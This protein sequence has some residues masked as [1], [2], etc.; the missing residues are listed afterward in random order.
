MKREYFLVILVLIL[1]MFLVSCSGG[2]TIVTPDTT[3]PVITLL[4]ENP[5]NLYVGDTYVE[6]GATAI[7][8]VD[9]DITSSVIIGGDVVNT[10]VVGTYV[11]TYN[12]S[13]SAGNTAI[14]VAIVINVGIPDG[15][16]ELI[17]EYVGFQEKVIRWPDGEVLVYD[18]TN[19][20]KTQKI[21]DELNEIIDGPLI[22][23]RTDN[24]NSADIEI[25]GETS[26][27]TCLLVLYPA[28]PIY[29]FSYVAINIDINCK[30]IEI[31]YRL[32]LLEAVGIW[33]WPLD[34]LDVLPEFSEELEA[35]L[36]WLYRL[37]LGY[38][39]P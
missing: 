32:G 30:D 24:R 4:G 2:G 10:S 34:S 9:G 16:L 28:I 39:L 18:A 23:Y 21:L 6:A 27:D 14:E 15:V 3:A 29:E 22:F 5:V 1:T 31:Y 11:V 33:T 7:D 13:D 12:V 8:D 20:D 26:E 19:Y 36:Y 25:F 37:P 38:E 17:K 35:V